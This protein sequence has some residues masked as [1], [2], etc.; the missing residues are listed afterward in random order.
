MAMGCVPVVDKE[1]DMKNYA[2]PPV[3]GVH[4]IRVSGPEGVQDVLAKISAEDWTTMSIAC[5]VW[6]KENSSCE[7]MWNLT[8]RLV[9]PA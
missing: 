4:Y 2:N 1:V 8:Q 9:L 7:G 6:W 5:C 3:E